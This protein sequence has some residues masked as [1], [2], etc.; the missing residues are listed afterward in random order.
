MYFRTLAIFSKGYFVNMPR[1]TERLV[2]LP[3][4]LVFTKIHRLAVRK[5]E[6]LTSAD[7]H[8]LPVLS[9]FFSVHEDLSPG[10]VL[11]ESFH[12]RECAAE[13]LKSLSYIR[14]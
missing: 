7:T 8:C 2:Y 9:R 5:K 14:P 11:C 3:G 1:N 10:G 12:R 4:K 6:P 13:T